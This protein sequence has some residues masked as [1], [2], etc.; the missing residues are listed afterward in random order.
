MEFATRSPG[1]SAGVDSSD[2]DGDAWLRRS[3]DCRS[4]PEAEAELLSCEPPLQ[5]LVVHAQGRAAPRVGVSDALGEQAHWRPRSGGAISRTDE[6]VKRARLADMARLSVAHPAVEALRRR[7]N[8][9][10]GD[11]SARS[12]ETTLKVGVLSGYERSHGIFS[13]HHGSGWHECGW[14]GCIHCGGWHGG[15]HDPTCPAPEGSCP[16]DGQLLFALPAGCE[17]RDP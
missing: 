8:G 15:C 9:R 14:R 17:A 2:H 1:G 3:E 16:R 11:T 5:Q 6:P 13:T 4:A 12:P 7:W 10:R